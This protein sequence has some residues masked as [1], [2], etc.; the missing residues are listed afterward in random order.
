MFVVLGWS[1]GAVEAISIIL[2][3]GF[4]VDY[5]LHVAEAFHMAPAREN[6]M[7]KVENA[8]SRV[9]RA[10]LS[11]GATTAGSA[12]FLFFC[13]IQVFNDFG[14]SVVLN[15]MWSLLFALIVYPSLLGSLPA[16]YHERSYLPS[17]GED[18]DET[19]TCWS[20]QQP[21]EADVTGRP[22]K[23]DE[24]LS[25][26]STTTIP[27]TD[28]SRNASLATGA[29]ASEYGR[30]VDEH[31][32]TEKYN[33]QVE[34]A[35]A[36]RERFNAVASGA[37]AGTASPSYRAVPATPSTSATRESMAPSTPG[38]ASV[39]PTPMA[40]RDDR[41]SPSFGIDESDVMKNRE[42]LDLDLDDD[43]CIDLRARHGSDLETVPPLDLQD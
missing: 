16:S 11:A 30:P 38:S 12:A 3:V 5:T 39:G 20:V 29:G 42:M 2:F 9:A 4:S 28:T 18:D 41:F 23:L 15:T 14:I 33:A 35:R 36:A 37:A 40:G 43:G 24:E 21:H 13:T 17:F 27:S 19:Q 7:N 6:G 31:I 32:Q 25:Q 22:V 1:F 10:I 8:M 34:A 26:P